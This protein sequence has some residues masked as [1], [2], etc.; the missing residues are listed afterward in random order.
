[1]CGKGAAL[2]NAGRPDRLA[3]ADKL[4]HKGAPREGRARGAPP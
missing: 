4:T 2:S 3:P 1:L